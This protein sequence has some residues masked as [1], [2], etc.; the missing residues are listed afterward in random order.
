LD[1]RETALAPFDLPLPAPAELIF[2]GW[3]RTVEVLAGEIG[4][5]CAK[6]ER[7]GDAEI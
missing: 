5:L 2:G 7:G 3:G 4:W 6:V 1:D